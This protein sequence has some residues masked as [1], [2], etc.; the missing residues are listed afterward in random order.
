MSHVE[1]KPDS[2]PVLVL[3]P[4]LLC[5]QALWAHQRDHLAELAEIVIADVTGADSIAGM[6]EAVLRQAPAGRF[7]LAG[8][9]M[10]GYV[11]LEIARRAPERIARLALLD[12]NA[13]ADTEEHKAR[14][15][16]LLAQSEMGDFKGATS[17]L[18]PLFLHPDHLADAELVERVTAMTVRVGKDAFVRQQQAI[19]NRPDARAWLG[20]IRVATL[21]LVGRQDAL[22]PVELHEE[23]A[24]RIS[25][26]KLV[27]VEDSGHLTT[28]EQPHAVSAVLRYWLQE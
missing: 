9:S 11:A 17:R 19:M 27:I 5:D 2:K 24:G 21:V 26:A 15:R 18:L 13:R 12:T 3:V 25:R 23:L 10:G 1:P 14:R 16:A 20:E 8:L 22:T 28:M 4:G 6:A 7:S